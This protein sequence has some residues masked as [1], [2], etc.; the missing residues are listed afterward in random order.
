MVSF[1]K[2]LP[3]FLLQGEI[4]ILIDVSTCLP[5]LMF[6]ITIGFPQPLNTVNQ[7]L[8]QFEVNYLNVFQYKCQWSV[9][10]GVHPVHE[11]I[12]GEDGLDSDRVRVIY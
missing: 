9:K 10:A 1:C 2:L 8:L 11:D 7:K 3:I 6:I 12:I 5:I 4:C